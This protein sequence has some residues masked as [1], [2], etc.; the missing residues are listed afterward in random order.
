MMRRRIFRPWNE[1]LALLTLACATAASAD[2]QA[3]LDEALINAQSRHAPILV[4]FHAPWCY[5]CYYM[6]RNV[7][8]GPEWD[9]VRKD[10][11]VVSL[12]ADSSEGTYWMQKLSVKGMP[13]YVVL[14]EQG[15]ELGRIQLE[16]TREEFYRQL[17]AI[18]ARTASLEGLGAHV[19]DGSP[20]SLRAARVVLHAYHAR[21]DADGG[22]AWFEG[23]PYA[24]HKA[25]LRDARTK[26]W[27]D[28]LRLLQ[29]AQAKDPAQ[30]MAAA[31]VVLGGELGCD[32]AYELDQV[33]ACTD[34]QPASQ[35]AQLLAGQKPVMTRLLYASV[36]VSHPSC[37]DARSEVLTTADLDKALGYGQAEADVLARAIADAKRRLD[38]NLRKDR[39]LADNL[40]VYLERADNT[41]ELDLLF[42][43]L[44]AAYPDDYVY[45]YRYGKSLA[46]R[47]QYKQALIYLQQAAAKAYGL[48]RLNVATQEVQALQ[49]LNRADD[50]KQAA[51]DALKANGP[52]FPDEAAKLRTL[53]GL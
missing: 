21:G 15:A 9:K 5:S 11:V 10:A 30:C 26:L 27:L 38:G 39:N 41:D 34:G 4:E 48:N 33:L 52:W 53:A 31:P 23:L 22:L 46:A 44:I 40:R 37:A 42:P 29:A 2:W 43:K 36:F 50:A 7:L 6:E 16:Q 32:R 20:A 45:P 1:A 8:N 13:N 35:R 19:K 12:D 24:A 49:K 51:A 28:R 14:N 25:L 3:P 18:F 17:D 47:G